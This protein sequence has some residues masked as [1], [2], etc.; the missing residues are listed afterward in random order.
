MISVIIP[1]LNEKRNILRIGNN[2]SKLKIVSEVIFIDDCS[3]DGT[4]NEIKKLSINNKFKGFLRR[5]K[6]RDLS[7]SVIYGVKIAKEKNIVVM[8]CDL[9]HNTKYIL[10]MWKV[11]KDSNIDIVVGSRFMKKKLSGNLGFIRSMSSNFTISFLNLVFSKK[12]SDPLSGFFLCKKEHITK[13]KKSFFAT[14]Y[15]ILFDIL[16]NGEK[17]LAVKDVSIFFNKKNFEKSK[18]NWRIIWIFLRQIF[19]TKLL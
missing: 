7:Q 19:Y 16:Y 10:S 1:T 14:G 4:F 6:T 8:D 2:L 11:F 3:T 9:Q 15:K 17:N 18:F 13:H 12:T 5:N